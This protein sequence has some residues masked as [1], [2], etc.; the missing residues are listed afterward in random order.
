MV[1]VPGRRE[2]DCAETQLLVQSH[3]R[4]L[5]NHGPSLRK[6]SLDLGTTGTSFV[7]IEDLPFI[8]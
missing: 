8:L 7:S 5:E 4:E 3:G 6:A 1:P 2:S